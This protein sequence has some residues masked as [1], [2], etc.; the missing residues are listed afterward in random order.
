VERQRLEA[1]LDGEPGT[2]AYWA[3]NR[4]TVARSRGALMSVASLARLSATRPAG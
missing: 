4:S 2:R 3:V 1:V